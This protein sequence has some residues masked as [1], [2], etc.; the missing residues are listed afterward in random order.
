METLLNNKDNRA[1]GDPP[2][3]ADFSEPETPPIGVDSPGA[4]ALP[5]ML[6]RSQYTR[7]SLSYLRDFFCHL[8]DRHAILSVGSR[9]NRNL[10]PTIESCVSQLEY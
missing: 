6:E 4:A 3:P 7:A 9:S 1:V 10:G 8:I 5:I 2:V